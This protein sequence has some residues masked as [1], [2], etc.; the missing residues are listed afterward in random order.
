MNPTELVDALA[1]NGGV[2][3]TS[4]LL[5]NMDESK[6][7]IPTTN[8]PSVNIAQVC[9]SVCECVC[10]CEYENGPLSLPP[11]TFGYAHTDVADDVHQACKKVSGMKD[12]TVGFDSCHEINFYKDSVTVHKQSGLPEYKK[13]FPGRLGWP[14]FNSK[15]TGEAHVTRHAADTRPI[16]VQ[17]AK[18]QNRREQVNDP[19]CAVKT[20]PKVIESAITQAFITT[21]EEIATFQQQHQSDPNIVSPQMTQSP[22]EDKTWAKR[23]NKTW[24]R[25]SPEVKAELTKEFNAAMSYPQDKTMRYNAEKSVGRLKD[26]L[27]KGRWDQKFSCRVSKV[28]GWFSTKLT[29]HTALEKKRVQ[30]EK[31]RLKNLEAWHLTW[32][33]DN[34]E[35][36]AMASDGIVARLSQEEDAM[37]SEAGAAVAG[38]TQSATSSSLAATGDEDDDDSY[39]QDAARHFNDT[40]PNPSYSLDQEYCEVDDAHESEMAGSARSELYLYIP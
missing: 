29:A 38:T 2:R 18:T 35:N 36:A 24:M 10:V 26:T 1:Y 19:D 14:S 3:G 6:F 20:L 16:H 30:E 25:L 15:H 5:V 7:I 12:L 11:S 4:L 34:P 31:T 9:A 39:E 22:F 28:K 23:A 33:R 37:P 40:Q 17:F 32:S 27:L 21:S 8:S 13:V